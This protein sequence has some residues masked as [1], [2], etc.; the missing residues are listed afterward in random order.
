MLP[1]G[2]NLALF[3][4]LTLVIL[5][6]FFYIL[7]THLAHQSRL[8]LTMQTVSLVMI[9]KDFKANTDSLSFIPHLAVRNEMEKWNKRTIF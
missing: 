7:L 5:N 2:W 3:Q 8:L 4:T 1:D 6:L 9:L